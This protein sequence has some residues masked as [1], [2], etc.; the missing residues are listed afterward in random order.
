MKTFA[1]ASLL[2]AVLAPSPISTAD[3][4]SPSGPLTQP[5]SVWLQVS[6]SCEGDTGSAEI[7]FPC[8]GQTAAQCCQTVRALYPNFVGVCQGDAEIQCG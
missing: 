3:P 4:A 6:S 2:L 8:P 5:E 7:S 1:L